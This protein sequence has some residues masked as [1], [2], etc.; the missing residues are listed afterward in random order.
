MFSAGWAAD[1]P[2][3]EDFIDKLFHSESVQNEQGYSNPEVDK[4]LLQARSE[5][6]QQ[7]RFALYAQAEQMILDDAAVIPD[8]WPVEHLLVKPCVKNWPSVSM[9]VPR[10]RYIEIAATEN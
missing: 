4:I 1:Y 2:D 5:S 8:F 7:K 10:Y 6:N 3:P 9:N